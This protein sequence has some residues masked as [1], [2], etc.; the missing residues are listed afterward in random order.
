MKRIGIRPGVLK[1]LQEKYSLSEAGL[2]RKIGI[3]VSMLWRI[4]H[5]RSRPGVEFIARTLAV[6]PEIRFED[7]FCIE[8]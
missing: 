4:K 7:A 5:G 3:D 8:E 2:A 6:F 1:A